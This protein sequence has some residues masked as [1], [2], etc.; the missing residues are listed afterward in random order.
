MS[1]IQGFEYAIAAAALFA[2]LLIYVLKLLSENKK[3][4][5][6]LLRETRILK[7]QHEEISSEKTEIEKLR[8]N[9]AQT[10]PRTFEE[11][12]K[13]QI[14]RKNSA[15]GIKNEYWDKIG[16]V[17][18]G[19]P[20]DDELKKLTD[21]KKNIEEMLELTKKKY[22]TRE[23]DEKSYSNITEDYQRKLIEVESKIKRLENGG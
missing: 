17:T 12:K 6:Q 5:A 2:A 10:D 15:E 11:M 1:N 20:E 16:K 14:T 4:K 22:H 8:K 13:A 18:G 23:I 9:A 19:K 21:E 7:K 3:L